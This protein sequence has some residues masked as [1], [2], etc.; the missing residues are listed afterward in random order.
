MKRIITIIILSLI[1]ASPGLAKSGFVEIPVRS[2]APESATPE[3]FPVEADVII[4]GDTF[5]FTHKHLGVAIEGTC[6]MTG[7]NAPEV[8]GK[9]KPLG[10]EASTKLAELL[11]QSQV[12]VKADKKDRYGRWLCDV[13]LEDGTHVNKAMRTWLE[14]K[15]YKGVGKY[16]HLEDK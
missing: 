8:R 10:L 7:Y 5:T 4:D 15:G 14:E 13:W 2:D 1:L 6:R 12:K 11:T 3:Y 9:E 16:D